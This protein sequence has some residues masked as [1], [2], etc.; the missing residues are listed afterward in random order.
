MTKSEQQFCRPGVM[1][2]TAQCDN[3]AERS[4][5]IYREMQA[6]EAA[7]AASLVARQQ[8]WAR[9]RAETPPHVV[10]LNPDDTDGGE[11]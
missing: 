5:R 4:L 11:S 6:R 3:C 7:A 2:C 9:L 8:W 10:R 1:P